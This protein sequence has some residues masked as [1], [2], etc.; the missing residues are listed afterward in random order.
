MRLAFDGTPHG[1]GLLSKIVFSEHERQKITAVDTGLLKE[2][3]SSFNC[4]GIVHLID[5]IDTPREAEMTEFGSHCIDFLGVVDGPFS[6]ENAMSLVGIMI[7]S[8]R[9]KISPLEWL[10]YLAKGFDRLS[11][12]QKEGFDVLCEDFAKLNETLASGEGFHVMTDKELAD[13]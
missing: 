4:S 13:L 7:G 8:H 2:T 11:E 5:T 12:I 3:F 9:K 6:F 10:S 1:Q